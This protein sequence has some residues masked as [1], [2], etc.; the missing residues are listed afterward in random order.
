MRKLA[1]VIRE[2]GAICQWSLML[3]LA[4]TMALSAA[5]PHMQ[6]SVATWTA[7]GSVA[8]GSLVA[9]AFF[10]HDFRPLD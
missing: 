9:S 3:F 5:A 8:V 4:S 10:D 6:G 1:W 2:V 7:V